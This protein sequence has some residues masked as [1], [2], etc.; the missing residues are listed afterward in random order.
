[1]AR[2]TGGRRLGVQRGHVRGHGIRV[3]AGDR[4]GQARVT[5]PQRIVEGR[6]QQRAE[7]A[8]RFGYPGGPEQVLGLGHQR[9]QVVG[10]A[11]ERRVVQVPV[12]LGDEH[13]LAAHLDRQG[14]GRGPE[15]LGRGNPEARPPQ[16]VHVVAAP[17]ERHHRMQRQ[18]QPAPAGRGFEHGQPVAAAR[19]HQHAPL[20]RSVRGRQPGH[21][22]R[23]NVVGHGEQGQV[24]LL[25]N[26][27]GVGDDR[28]GEGRAGPAHGGLGHRG[29]GDHSVPGASERRAERGT[30]PPGADDAD[31][32]PGRVLGNRMRGGQRARAGLRAGGMIRV[33]LRSSPHGYRTVADPG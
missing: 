3:A 6:G 28:A 20:H 27:A 31:G 23:Q 12:L 29:D 17:G 11:R 8:R 22:A 32:E 13:R 10:G 24:G 7:Q 33:H 15:Y 18:R 25:E 2:L 5:E 9:D 19:V 16:P 21:Q 1:M 26:Q 4:A 30:C 14:L